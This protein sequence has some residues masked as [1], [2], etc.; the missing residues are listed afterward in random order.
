[1][2]FL[3]NL[4]TPR[5]IRRTHLDHFKN[6]LNFLNNLPPNVKPTNKELIKDQIA[7]LEKTFEYTIW[8]QPNKSSTES[9]ITYYSDKERHLF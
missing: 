4:W 6:R 8:I 5:N 7:L 3:K 2:G 1:M 9:Q